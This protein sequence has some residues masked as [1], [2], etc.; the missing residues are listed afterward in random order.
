MPITELQSLSQFEEAIKS[1][2]LTVI[3]FSTPDCIPCKMIAPVYDKYS[4]YYKG[5]KYYNCDCEEQVEVAALIPVTNVPTFA[6]YKEGEL[7]LLVSG[8]GADVTKL[9]SGIRKYATKEPAKKKT[10]ADVKK[11]VKGRRRKTV[12]K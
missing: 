3:K 7:V 8:E 10:S 6:L 2:E 11:T 9:K 5:A 4:K 12:K 1:T